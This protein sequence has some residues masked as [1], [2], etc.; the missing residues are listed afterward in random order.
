MCTN[1]YVIQMCTDGLLLNTAH[2][3][4]M[5]RPYSEDFLM[6]NYPTYN[7]IVEID[8]GEHLGVESTR[9]PANSRLR[10]ADNVKQVQ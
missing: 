1:T 10:V 6:N 7:E 2:T 4:L 8:K 9:N 3:R 5:H